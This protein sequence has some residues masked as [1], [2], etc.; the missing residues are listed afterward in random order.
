MGQVSIL[1][2]LC[3]LF[4]SLKLYK[5]RQ[6]HFITK[7]HVILDEPRDYYKAILQELCDR[8][9]TR[10]SSKETL[11]ACLQV[12]LYIFSEYGDLVKNYKQPELGLSG[13]VQEIA[14]NEPSDDDSVVSELS[15]Y[16][17][18]LEM[19]TWPLRDFRMTFLH[20][21]ISW[22]PTVLRRK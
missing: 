13:F 7:M 6:A 17:M 8:I 4:E 15:M 12:M 11:G 5:G 9:R 19:R 10:K 2:I 22:R 3:L 14:A 16:F 21:R 1:W 18:E 20:Y